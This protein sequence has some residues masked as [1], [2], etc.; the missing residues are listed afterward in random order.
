[1]KKFKKLSLLVL[2]T[3]LIGGGLIGMTSCDGG[4]ENSDSISQ[5]V[6]KTLESISITSLPTKTDYVEGDFFD[7]T[8]MVV[9]ALYSDSSTSKV[10]TYT[11]DKTGALKLTDTTVTVTYQKK[12]ATLNITITAKPP[13]EYDTLLTIEN[14]D[15]ETYRVEAEKC[16]TTECT[17]Q[18]GT[19]GFVESTDL[20]SDGQCLACIGTPGNIIK[21]PFELKTEATIKIT[22]AM[23]KYEDNWDLIWNVKFYL[24][25]KEFTPVVDGKFGRKEDGSNDWY[26]WTNVVLGTFEKLSTGV[27][28]LELRIQAV[29]PN[30]DYFDFA[31]SPE[32]AQLESLSIATPPNKTIYAVGDKFDKTG[33]VVKAN[34]SDDSS[35]EVTD[36]T[37]APEGELTTSDTEIIISYTQNGITKTVS[38]AISVKEAVLESIAITTNPTKMEY[39]VGET[40]DPSGMVVTATFSDSSTE[41]VTNY[42]IDKT[43]P[44]TLE[45]TVVTISYQGISTTLNIEVNDLDFK[46]SDIGDYRVEAENIDLSNV[47]FQPGK[48]SFVEN[49]TFSSNGASIGGLGEGNFSIKFQTDKAYILSVSS[50]MAKYESDY[51]LTGNLTFSLDGTD[52]TPTQPDSYGTAEGNDWFNF[53]TVSFDAQSIEAGTHEFKVTITGEAPNIDCFDFK[54]SSTTV[55]IQSIAITTN[56]TKMEYKVGETFDPSGMVVTA[57]FSDSS[58]E[59]ITDYSIDKTGK[60]T[61]DDTVIT[62]SYLGVSTTLDITVTDLSFVANQAGDYRVEAENIDLSNV[63][64]QPGKDSFVESNTFSSNGA[65]IGGLGEGNFSIKFQTSAT[66]EVSIS[67]LM[68]KYESDYTLTGNLT[69][70]LDGTDLTPTQPD[71]Y[72]TVEGN[73]WFNFKTVSF[74]AQSIEDGTHEFKVT[75]TGEAPNIDCFDFNLNTK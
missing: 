67:S 5:N 27:H 73:D 59:E 35:K 19:S 40:F 32:E 38:Q 13:H 55:N 37:Y 45:D 41:E 70:S 47:S 53:K 11:V 17:L 39:K 74:D 23:A 69:F 36:Y 33:M 68:A 71:S 75:I 31:V 15:S 64:F 34:Y 46:A 61:I 8:G 9:T 56:P 29:A 20:A 48:D 24:D 12:T 7:R 72:G 54:L 43:N 22:S 44:L 1:M 63:S 4:S 52:L 58:T 30:I 50:L 2:S 21:L 10:T 66:Y 51:T 49:N 28:T 62:I 14:A 16:D 25:D 26:N 3:F 18:E 6:V 42:S 65:S 60:L 57:T